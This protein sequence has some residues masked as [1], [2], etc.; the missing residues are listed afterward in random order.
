MTREEKVRAKLETLATTTLWAGAIFCILVWLYFIY[1]YGWAKNRQLTSLIGLGMYYVLP[2]VMATLLFAFSRLRPVYKV[3]AAMACISLAV[4]IYGAEILLPTE[5]AYTLGIES[6]NRTLLEAVNGFRQNGADAV[7]TIAPRDLLKPHDDGTLRSVINNSGTEVLP[8]GGISNKLTIFCNE[9]GK[10]ITYDS[11]EHGFHNPT[12]I[13]NSD[14][15]EIATV[16]DSF[17]HGWC[18]PSET[19]FVALLRKYHPITLNLGMGGSGPLLE[20][21]ALKEF[22]PPLR[23]KIVLWFYYETNDL[24]DLRD[25]QKSALLMRYLRSNFTQGL[26]RRQREIDQALL[27]FVEQRRK[28]LDEQKLTRKAQTLADNLWSVIALSNLRLKLGAIYGR[29]T[30]KLQTAEKADFDL[31]RDVLL[32]AKVTVNQWSGLL[33][34]V[35]LPAWERYANPQPAHNDRAPVLDLVSRL[36]IPIIDLHPAFQAQRD[37]LSLFPSRRFGHYNETGYEL[38]AREVLKAISSNYY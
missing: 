36:Q 29:T 13:W 20:L 2:A 31:F 16:G 28:S 14:R 38:V 17:A 10:Y 37:P 1:E 23:P 3:N 22:L 34:F 4:P 32:E 35:F 6:D 12:G 24:T 33:Y 8:L 5:L 25:E 30:Y 27:D 19:H 21:A 15:L 7:P 18:V 9:T 11:D 26:S